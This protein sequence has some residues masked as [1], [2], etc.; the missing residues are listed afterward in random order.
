MPV[1]AAKAGLLCSRLS[2]VSIG[3]FFLIRRSLG[4][5]GLKADVV[6]QDEDFLVL[7]HSVSAISFPARLS[8]RKFR[9]TQCGPVAI[10]SEFLV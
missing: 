3:C 2:G 10:D 5:D 9:D 4:A 8:Y 7:L 1:L 6:G